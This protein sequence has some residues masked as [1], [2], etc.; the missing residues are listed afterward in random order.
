MAIKIQVS[1]EKSS[2]MVE[3]FNKEYEV[4][5]DDEALKKYEEIHKKYEKIDGEEQAFSEFIAFGKEMLEGFIG[6]DNYEEIY[7]KVGRSTVA[8]VDIVTQIS[9]VVYS[10]NEKFVNKAHK[11]LSAKAKKQKM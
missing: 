5:Y 1:Q 11:Y 10:K 2:E 8:I 4:H 3:I 7:G 9:N 6:E